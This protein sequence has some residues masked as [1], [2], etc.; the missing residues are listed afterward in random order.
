MMQ[1]VKSSSIASIGHDGKA[2]HIQ[3]QSG[4][5]YRY[6]TATQK[7]YQAMLKAKSVGTHFAAN[8]RDKH[9]GVKV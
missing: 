6:P 5:T 8:I 9:K 3:F 4:D 2:L 1:K 7:D